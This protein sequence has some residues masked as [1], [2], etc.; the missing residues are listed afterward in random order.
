MAIADI[1]LPVT[2]K[3]DARGL[4]KAEGELKKFGANIGKVIAG[5]TA[6]VAGIGIASVKAFADF[7]DA[8][9]KSLAIMGDVSDSMRE[10]MS[11]AAR[12]VAKTTT[13]SAE[14]AAESF[15][16]LASAG[17]DAEQ[18]LAALPAVANFAQAGMFDMATATD[19]LTDA[20]SALGMGS[21]D[22]AKNL[23]NMINLSDML[24]TANTSANA[25]VEEF[26]EAL[27]TKGAV[28]M[29]QFGLET[30]EGI[31]MLSVFADGGIKGSR[32]GT[33][34]SATLN[35]MAKNAEDNAGAFEDLGV[36]VFDSEGQTRDMVDIVQDLEGSME[37]M[38]DQ[39][40]L[41][42]LSGLGFNRQALEGVG[43]LVGNSDALEGFTDSVQDAG[44]ATDEVANKQLESFN[45]QMSLLKSAIVDVGLEIG[46]DLIPLFVALVEDMKPLI[47][48]ATPALT[49]M[50][51]GLIP[52]LMD[53]VDGFPDFVDALIPLIPIMGDIAGLVAEA[54]LVLFPVFLEILQLLLPVFDFLA[55]ALRENTTMITAVVGSIAGL[56]ILGTGI[57]NLITLFSA[58][59]TVM[60]ALRITTILQ[61]VA[62]GAA[63]VAQTLFNAVLRA[64]PIGL[65]ITAITLLIGAL[66]FFFTKTELGQELW[67]KFVNFLT[68]AT[69]G[70]VDFFTELFTEQIP[71]VWAGMIEGITAGWEA[72]KEFFFTALEAI[73]DFFRGIINGWI[74]MFESFVNFLIGGVN[75]I[76][77]AMN[78]ISVDIPAGPFTDAFSVGV[79]LPTVPSVSL[80]R[81]ADG[82]I[83][84]SATIALIGEAGPEAVIPLDRMDR[85]GGGATYN[86]TVNSGVGDP[87]RIGEEVINSI[88]RFERASGPVFARA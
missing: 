68:E 11:D 13:F 84:D 75:N 9:T 43:L 28:A 20:Q 87:V 1:V 56:I 51:L 24:V 5:A 65:V 35:S 55:E 23:E 42:T 60:A 70:F 79:S 4:R 22:A 83:V 48:E 66:V 16:F 14:E 44:G 17:L 38:S 6:T 61:T 81:L 85:M 53:L 47:E 77:R 8:M 32:A 7:D 10:E 27:T 80:P 69:Q 46:S 31:G 49:D 45:A 19:L 37:G 63:T 82:G 58:F 18:Q 50:F 71:A 3:S 78:T 25:S 88:K 64:N 15:F 67:A 54:A 59:R 26:S 39:Q 29:G 41:A 76:I 86:I 12:E 33:L 72:F 62:T 73:G 30:E 36:A 57:A 74:S 21:D 2:F 52:V 40:R 34:L